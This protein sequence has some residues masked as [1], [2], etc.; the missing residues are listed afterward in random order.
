MQKLN[1]DKKGDFQAHYFGELIKRYF[2][3]GNARGSKNIAHDIEQIMLGLS[4]AYDKADEST[5]NE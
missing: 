4:N 3:G 2:E 1:F 5:P